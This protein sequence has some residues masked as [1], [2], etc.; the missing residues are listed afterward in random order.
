MSGTPD[1][2]LS[3]EKGDGPG[4]QR[5]TSDPSSSTAG[6]FQPPPKLENQF[7]EDIAL[8]RTLALYLP[9]SILSTIQSD[10]SSFGERVLSCRVLGWVSDAEQNP[11]FVRT[12]DTWGRRKDELVT[13]EGWKRLQDLGIAEGMVAAGYETGKFAEFSRVVQF[14]K[15]HLWAGSSAYVTCPSA[16]Q[17]GAARVLQRHLTSSSLPTDIRSALGPAYSRLTSRDPTKAWTSGQWMTERKGGSDVSGTETLAT[18]SPLDPPAKDIH[19]TDLGPWILDGFKW[20]SSATDSSMALALAQTPRGLSLFFAPTRRLAAN[21]VDAEL[22]GISIQQLK[23]KL[24]TR[25][26]PTAE[27]ELKGMRAWLVGEEGKG[28]REISTMLNITRVHNAVMGMGMWGRGLAISRAFAKV[29]GVGGEGKKLLVDV[30]LHVRTM[31]GQCVEYRGFMHL[32]FFVVLLLGLDEQQQQQ[33]PRKPLDLPLSAL[34]PVNPSDIPPLLRILTPVAKSQTAKSAIAS[35]AE[36]MESLGGI[37]YLE[38]SDPELNVARLF[39]DANVLSIWEGTTDVLAVDAVKV[40]KGHE[41]GSVL[42]AMDGWLRWVLRGLAGSE[43]FTEIRNV[44]LSE[45]VKLSANV[46]QTETEELKLRG[47]EITKAISR[48]VS[49]ALLAVDAERDG[50][51]AAREVARRW[52]LGGRSAKGVSGGWM[53]EVEWDKKIVFGDALGKGAKL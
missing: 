28:V 11:P 49:G 44:L 27:L 43:L 40:L 3:M 19:G 5:H 8:R 13:S 32:T 33:Q 51:G 39:R 14:G 6:F 4:T 50:D 38:N 30:P 18:Y 35:L 17:D 2:S 12:H 7:E 47:R 9:A 10:F 1:G 24:G 29:R 37:G 21:G 25:A 53:E 46:S 23:S 22:N 15:Y 31:A 42:R 16:M 45:W 26:L 36:C 34:L 41:G 52:V 48:I 20:F